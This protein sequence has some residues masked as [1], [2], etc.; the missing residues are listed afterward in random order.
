MSTKRTSIYLA[1]ALLLTLTSLS[2][3]VER[4]SVTQELSGSTTDAGE[5]PMASDTT[6]DVVVGLPNNAPRE[7]QPTAALLGQ[8]T[9]VDRRSKSSTG[10]SRSPLRRALDL[11]LYLSHCVFL[12]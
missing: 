11:A 2:L 3:G 10:S 5:L 12:C 8:A 1:L 9:P 6:G 4:A 7:L